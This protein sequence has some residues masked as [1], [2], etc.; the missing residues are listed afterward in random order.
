M[1]RI[2]LLICICCEIISPS[3]CQGRIRNRDFV[4]QQIGIPA[5]MAK[6]DELYNFYIDIS[7]STTAAR[8]IKLEA[9]KGQIIDWVGIVSDS[10][11]STDG[12]Y[13]LLVDLGGDKIDMMA[14][15]EAK[16]TNF[17]DG[18]NFF[19]ELVILIPVT[20]DDVLK[21]KKGDYIHIN[22]KVADFE[23]PRDIPVHMG[24]SIILAQE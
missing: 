3:L 7:T 9:L 18:Y 17:I 22:R 14:E 1:K 23:M 21:Y 8:K 11:Q 13:W 5:Y 24:P 4:R 20:R 15:E 10:M 19:I 6:Y 12:S 16:G 2:V